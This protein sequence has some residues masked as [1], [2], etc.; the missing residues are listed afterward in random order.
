MN[1]I[2]P[3]LQESPIDMQGKTCIAFISM[4]K[5]KWNLPPSLS[6]SYWPDLKT[7]KVEITALVK[8]Q[9]T[10]GCKTKLDRPWCLCKIMETTEQFYSWILSLN[11]L[12]IFV[13]IRDDA[14]CYF[15]SS[16]EGDVFY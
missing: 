3:K 16:L 9:M 13:M 12:G 5:S 4:W 1:V 14:L 10:I 11:T 8:H 7:C 2:S 6:D 15:R